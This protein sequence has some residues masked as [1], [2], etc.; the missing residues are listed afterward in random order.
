M[1]HFFN[2]MTAHET[3]FKQHGQKVT[4]DKA[5]IFVRPEDENPWVYFLDNG[6]VEIAYGFNDGSNRLMGYFFPGV[7]FAQNGS[8]FTNDGSGLEYIATKDLVLYRI[9]K[10]KFFE[11]ITNNPECNKEYMDLLIR[12]QFL[13]IERVAYMGER[14]VGKVVMRLILSLSKYY[15]H[16]ENGAYHIDAPI[17]QET[18]ARLS[19]ATRESVSKTLRKLI[20]DNII[21]IKNKQLIITNPDKLRNLLEQ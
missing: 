2:R 10:V 12:N 7:V 13:L 21:S 4:Y 19:H 1:T 9:S 8:F 6:L 3:Y 11:L 15:G 14:G 5:Q 17:T 18:I 20:G 16:E